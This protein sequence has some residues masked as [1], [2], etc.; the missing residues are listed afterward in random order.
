MDELE[1]RLRRY[2]PVGPPSSLRAR[3]VAAAG[4]TPQ[5]RWVWMPSAAA[6]AL[7]FMFYVLAASARRDL[8]QELTRIDPRREAVV[9]ALASDL[10]GDEEATEVAASL[11]ELNE[12]TAAAAG[13][14]PG[15]PPDVESGR[16]ER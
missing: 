10:G 9:R 2:R 13:A 1:E 15:L 11:I 3:V 5:R 14:D 4:S 7:A 12:S 6:A 16:G 8:S